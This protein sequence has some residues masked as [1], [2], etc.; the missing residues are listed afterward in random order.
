[1]LAVK[2]FVVW[3]GLVRNVYPHPVS[4]TELSH[5]F[6]AI[7]NDGLQVRFGLLGYF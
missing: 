2:A 5:C 6:T 7:F 4:L 3:V 1:M